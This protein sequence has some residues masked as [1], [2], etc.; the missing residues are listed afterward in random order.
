MSK[1]S[2]LSI[3]KQ[4]T[5]RRIA[6]LLGG[7]KPRSAVLRIKTDTHNSVKHPSES[8]SDYW[9]LCRAIVDAAGDLASKDKMLMNFRDKSKAFNV[10]PVIDKY[11]NGDVNQLKLAREEAVKTF[12]KAVD[13]INWYSRKHDL[14]QVSAMK[15][16]GL[17]EDEKTRAKFRRHLKR[18]EE[19]NH[20]PFELDELPIRDFRKTRD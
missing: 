7:D 12:F 10:K 11:Y 16:M 20:S 5:G 17:L 15:L 3:E 8:Y 2:E 13:E 4:E 19:E 14:A 6:D 1:M 18:H 9:T